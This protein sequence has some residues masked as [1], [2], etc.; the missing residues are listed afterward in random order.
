MMWIRRFGLGLLAVL[1]SPATAKLVSMSQDLMLQSIKQGILASFFPLE[2]AMDLQLL[3]CIFSF[4]LNPPPFLNLIHE[5]N[6]EI[7]PVWCPPFTWLVLGIFLR[8]QHCV[9]TSTKFDRKTLAME[10]LLCIF[11]GYLPYL[12]PDTPL[13]LVIFLQLD[14]CGDAPSIMTLGIIVR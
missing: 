10:G 2:V 4:I 3:F 8:I 13:G 9:G 6:L 5:L 11:I 14:K 12:E 1:F 7:G